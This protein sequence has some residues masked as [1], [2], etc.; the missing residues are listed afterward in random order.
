MRFTPYP[1]RREPS[2][3]RPAFWIGVVA[4]LV[5]VGALIGHFLFPSN[6]GGGPVADEP[7][8]EPS[9]VVPAVPPV[10]SPAFTPTPVVSPTP[11]STPTP[12][13]SPTPVPSVSGSPVSS[14]D[15][16]GAGAYAWVKLA[17][18]TP[19]DKASN[20]TLAMY[21]ATYR[22]TG[23][24]S[25]NGQDYPD[26]I[27]FGVGY[28]T[29]RFAPGVTAWATYDL[30]KKCSVFE[31]TAG[32]DSSTRDPAWTFYP[33]VLLNDQ[34]VV[35]DSNGLVLEDTVVGIYNP[36]PLRVD[37][38]GTLRLT[39]GGTMAAN[40][41]YAQGIDTLIMGTARVWCETS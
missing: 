19:V 33:Y 21:S 12:S 11:V 40:P 39:I 26:S 18:L 17:D 16:S 25:L 32:I 22:G 9:T 31:A 30:G 37:I 20:A 10:T 28:G 14:S 29:A 4:V 41:N 15:P 6:P 38:T 36:V 5:V 24:F 3:F 8:S 13:V 23:V 2:R 7:S 35:T 27:R 34:P 1:Q